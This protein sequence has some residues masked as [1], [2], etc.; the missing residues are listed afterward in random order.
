MITLWNRRELTVTQ[1]LQRQA[2][3]REALSAANIKYYLKTVNMAPVSRSRTG[4]LGLNPDYLMEYLFYVH[5]NDYERAQFLI[6]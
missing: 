1:S 2:E 3:I 4:M 6:R 5:K